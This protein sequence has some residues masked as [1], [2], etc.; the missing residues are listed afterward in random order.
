MDV[1]D[2]YREGRDGCGFGVV[3]GVVASLLFL[4]WCFL[5]T[6]C[7]TTRIST[8]T[9][10]KDSTVVHHQYDTTHI[11]VQDTNRV[12]Q[13]VQINDTSF[14][15]IQFAQ[16]GGTYNAKTG[17]ATNVSSV[18]QSEGH[19]EQRDSTS[20]YKRALE[21]AVAKSDSLSSQVSEYE[22]ELQEEKSYP[23]RSGWDRFCTWWFLI[24]AL[25]LLAKLA[26]WVMEKIPATA[27][28]IATIRK[29]V[30]FL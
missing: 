12:E 20:F 22:Y 11:V 16:G 27:P 5:T 2:R 1:Y 26:C 9:N 7:T 18:Q 3:T 25:L 13:H 14:V 6:G 29:F 10:T 19:R 15:L 21:I 23:K 30:P 17:E 28:Y 24:T 4:L 8:K